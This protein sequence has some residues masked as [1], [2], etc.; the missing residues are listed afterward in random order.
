M[1][2]YRSKSGDRETAGNNGLKGKNKRVENGF[3]V[4][5]IGNLTSTMAPLLTNELERIAHS[6]RA[7]S[8][9]QIPPATDKRG[10]IYKF[11]IVF[12]K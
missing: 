1:S 10:F 9:S 11:P 6:L 2:S 8:Y 4:V 12:G 5:T 3:V 7:T